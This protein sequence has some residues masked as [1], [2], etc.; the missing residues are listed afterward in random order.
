MKC[1]EL[2]TFSR[3]CTTVD[4]VPVDLETIGTLKILERLHFDLKCVLIECPHRPSYFS[5]LIVVL[6]HA[7][8]EVGQLA[9][10]IDVFNAACV[11]HVSYALQ[12][13][14]LAFEGISVSFIFPM[15]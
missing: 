12:R 15:L 7:M 1:E 11:D 13:P 4:W 6:N 14:E 5:G 8:N 3:V 9:V 10:I 2:G